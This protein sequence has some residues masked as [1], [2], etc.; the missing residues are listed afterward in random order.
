M[1]RGGWIVMGKMDAPA[2]LKPLAYV[3]W[4]DE[5]TNI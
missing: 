3:V 4:V 2:N 1:L 5:S